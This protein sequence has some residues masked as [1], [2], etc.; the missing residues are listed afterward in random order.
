MHRLPLHLSRADSQIRPELP[1]L[2]A[3]ADS[4]CRP[5]RV[6]PARELPSA[7]EQAGSSLAGQADPAGDAASEDAAY[8]VGGVYIRQ[9]EGY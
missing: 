6:G 7:A 2:P 4:A 1:D 8:S 9:G 5:G 3:R